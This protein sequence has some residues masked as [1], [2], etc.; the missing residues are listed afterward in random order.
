MPDAEVEEV[1]AQHP[2]ALEGQDLESRRQR[3]QL[4]SSQRLPPRKTETMLLRHPPR[5][6]PPSLRN[7]SFTLLRIDEGDR[8]AGS[9]W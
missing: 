4:L 9:E 5:L 6:R 7:C 3:A 2:A 1:A 8:A